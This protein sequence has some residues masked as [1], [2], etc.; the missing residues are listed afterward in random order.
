MLL[1]KESFIKKAKVANKEKLL[2]YGIFLTAWILSI[3]LLFQFSANNELNISPP[4]LIVPSKFDLPSNQIR[5]FRFVR[6]NPGKNNKP[7]FCVSFD[8]LLI[9]NNKLGIFKSALH[10][11]VRISNLE[12][13]SYHYPENLTEPS[14]SIHN[15]LSKENSETQVRNRSDD[16]LHNLLFPN[17]TIAQVRSCIDNLLDKQDGWRINLD[18]SSGNV[19][20]LVINNF[21]YSIFSGNDLVLSIQ[22]KRAIASYSSS[23]L[24]LRGHV[25]IKTGKGNTLESNCIEWDI[26]NNIFTV[27]G[28]YVLNQNGTVKTGR[29]VTLDHTLNEIIP[30]QT[31]KDCQEEKTKCFTKL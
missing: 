7:S 27:Q 30:K 23:G 13:R 20:E 28:V 14:D 31:V 24:I 21:S 8:N 10:Q 22:S 12:F 3:C 29:D 11:I 17:N 25:I 1:S 16:C 2:K 15:W 26:N 19:S 4:K 9:E 5:A 18:I 6:Y